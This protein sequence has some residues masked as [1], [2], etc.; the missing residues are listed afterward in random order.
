[1]LVYNRHF[2]H[3]QNVFAKTSTIR[4]TTK[5]MQL[6]FEFIHQVHIYTYIYVHTMII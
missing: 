3:S 2:Q 4:M 5:L 1:M 6:A